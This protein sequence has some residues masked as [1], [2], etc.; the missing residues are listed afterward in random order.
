MKINVKMAS[1]L[2]DLVPGK[3]YKILSA[4]V[5]KTSVR[6]FE[7]IRVICEATDTK[8]Q[9]ATMLWLRDVAGENSKVGAFLKAFADFLGDEEEARDTDNW[10][11]HIIEVISW[12]IRNRKIR[13]VK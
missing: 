7:G 6:G 3:N 2:P 1:S 4:E 10:K 12:A 11:G 9:Y 8:D 5:V 13:V